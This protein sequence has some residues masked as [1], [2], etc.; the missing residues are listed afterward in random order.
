MTTIL[1]GS[2][3]LGCCQYCDE[4]C[5]CCCT[6]VIYPTI[7]QAR[8]VVKWPAFTTLDLIDC[9]AGSGEVTVPL[10][11][12]YPDF[13]NDGGEGHWGPPV[14]HKCSWAYNSPIFGIW[15]GNNCLDYFLMGPGGIPGAGCDPIPY[16]LAYLVFYCLCKDGPHVCDGTVEPNHYG[17]YQSAGSNIAGWFGKGCM[18]TFQNCQCP[19]DP[20][21]QAINLFMND[22]RCD[23]QRVLGPCDPCNGSICCQ[24]ASGACIG[25][26]P[27]MPGDCPGESCCPLYM[28][29]WQGAYI[30][31]TS[32]SQPC[33]TCTTRDYIDCVNGIHHIQDVDYPASSIGFIEITGDTICAEPV[34]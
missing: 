11:N 24:A 28:K 21:G 30:F 13:V 9:P 16:Y 29:F 15:P 20:P 26:A 19:P 7:L 17:C 4:Q 6:N 5:P 1:L 2:R 18:T 33:D 12:V 34:V 3:K 14:H 22:Y 32:L 27:T 10:T 8:I 25:D 23:T 31:D